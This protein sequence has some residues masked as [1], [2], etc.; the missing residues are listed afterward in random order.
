MSTGDF[1]DIRDV[2]E[3]WTKALRAKDAGGIIACQSE[4]IR[5][6]S[7]APPLE[8][9]GNDR[10]G[11]QAWLDTWDGGL[12]FEI[13]NTDLRVGGDTGWCSALAFLAGSKIGKEKMGF[14]FRLTVAFAREGGR[15][16]IVHVHESVPFAMEGQPLAI[17]D[18]QP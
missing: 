5:N 12:E 2:L 10:A 13:R 16:V 3:T 17:F 11:L 15:W 18:L 6:F 14:W 9:I 4:T 7:L 1:D 8:Q